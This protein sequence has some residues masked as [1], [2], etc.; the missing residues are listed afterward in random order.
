MDDDDWTG[1]P[2]EGRHPRERARPEFWR[3]LWQTYGVGAG[4]LMA[5]VG[6]LV[7]VILSR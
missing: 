1:T 2:P 4:L 6:V 3:S 5:I 7:V